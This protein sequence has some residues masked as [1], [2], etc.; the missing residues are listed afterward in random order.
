[1]I[2][3][4]ALLYDSCNK[5]KWEINQGLMICAVCEMF[6]LTGVKR[7]GLLSE[8]IT[9]TPGARPQPPLERANL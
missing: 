2:L 1:M 9:T 6:D 8:E 3:L 4:E 5:L 7:G